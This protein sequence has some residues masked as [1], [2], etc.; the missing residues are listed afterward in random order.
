MNCICLLSTTNKQNGYI[1]YC[2]CCSLACVFVLKFKCAVHVIARKLHT[3]VSVV[4]RIEYMYQI[5]SSRVLYFFSFF[6]LF[7]LEPITMS[8]SHSF[9][10]WLLFYGLCIL[11]MKRSTEC[12]IWF[13]CLKILTGSCV[14]RFTL[15]TNTLRSC[16]LRWQ[17]VIPLVAKPKQKPAPFVRSICKWQ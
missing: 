7:Y 11:K 17:V 5:L 13:W 9:V 3:C 6:I 14:T 4:F 1:F 10:C 12:V 8:L 15:N 16:V 2:V